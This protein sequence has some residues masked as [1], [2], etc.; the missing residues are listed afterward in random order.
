MA[1]S[2]LK[3]LGPC[4]F[5]KNLGASPNVNAAG[6]ENAAGLIQSLIERLA[7][8]GF[9]PGTMFG[10]WLKPKP[11]LFDAGWMESGNPDSAVRIPLHAQPPR[12]AFTGVLHSEPNRLPLPTGKS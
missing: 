8:T 11:T 5:A 6:C 4:R 10:R 3:K 2:Q 7:G 9:T 12:I 1:M